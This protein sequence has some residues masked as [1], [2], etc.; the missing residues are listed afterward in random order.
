MARPRPR[1]TAAA[2]DAEV[3]ERWDAAAIDADV[4]ANQAARATV[5]RALREG[6]FEA[7]DYVPQSDA[8]NQYMRNHFDLN[9]V[10]SGRRG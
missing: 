9:D 6:R 1:V 4:R 7:W 3:A 8:L 2:F 10:E 5:D